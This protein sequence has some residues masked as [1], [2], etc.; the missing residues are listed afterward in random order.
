MA[1]ELLR[2]NWHVA[3]I[4][5]P[6][7]LLITGVLI[8]L[9]S[10]GWRNVSLKTAGRWMIFLGALAMIPASLSGLYAF[11]DVMRTDNAAGPYAIWGET[12]VGSPLAGG[13]YLALQ[14]HA[15][16][17]GVATVLCL[18]GSVLWAGLSDRGRRFFHVPA[19]GLILLGVGVMVAGAWFGGEAIYGHGA[20]VRLAQSDAPEFDPAA[21]GA[22]T[23]ATRIAWYLPP[24]QTHLALAGLAFAVCLGALAVCMRAIAEAD[25]VQLRALR[26]DEIEAMLDDMEPAPQRPAL[27]TLRFW[28]LGF[29]L[30]LLAAASGWWF[31]AYDSDLWEFAA[32]QEMTLGS[33]RRLYH[34]VLGAGAIG[35]PL[36]LAIAVRLAPRSKAVLGIL[37]AVLVAVMGVQTWLGILLLL[38]TPEGPPTGFNVAAMNYP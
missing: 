16:M 2:P 13:A 31:L 12:V 3:L 22:A 33:P 36:A 11:S 19:M 9:L 29:L 35:L 18:L 28:V 26:R 34:V 6:M 37:A 38:D 27:P 15:W 1:D 7:G 5:F 21:Q 32:L 30:A 4:H 24:L 25:E 17:Q 10:F 8:E 23:T 14:R 20:G